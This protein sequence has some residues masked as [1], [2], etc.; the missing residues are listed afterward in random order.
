MGSDEGSARVGREAR[1]AVVSVRVSEEE[2]TRL[3]K[4][5]DS[6]GTSVSE[7]VRSVVVREVTPREDQPA[8]ITTNTISK[9]TVA[10]QGVFWQLP[11]GATSPAPATVVIQAG[12]R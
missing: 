9:A 7:F 6:R 11:E 1:G 4:V 2:Q 5:A 10:G 8:V 3:R 12:R